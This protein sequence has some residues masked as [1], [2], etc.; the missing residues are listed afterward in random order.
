MSVT[1]EPAQVVAGPVITGAGAALI[2]T[3]LFELALQ[4]PFAT[5]TLM[6][7]L[8][9]APAVKTMAFVPAPLVI[10]PFVTLQV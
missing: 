9:E 3:D 10:E 2:G 1:G 7:T 5:V 8:P 4:P 6:A